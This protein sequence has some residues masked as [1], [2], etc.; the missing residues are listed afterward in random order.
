ME[1]I[2]ITTPIEKHKIR[3]KKWLTGRAVREINAVLTS[4][5]EIE[6]G[7]EAKFKGEKITAM[8]DKQIEMTI[9]DID[10]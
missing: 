3:L 7:M 8:I 2:E 6:Q 5:M 10:D 4:D 1:S 9:L